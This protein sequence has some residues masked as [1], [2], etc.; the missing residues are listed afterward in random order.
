MFRYQVG[1]IPS[2]EDKTLIIKFLRTLTG[3]W[4]GKPL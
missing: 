3:E 2:G 1:R 4:E